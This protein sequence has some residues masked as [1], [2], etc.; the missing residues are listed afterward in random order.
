VTRDGT[1]QGDV[2]VRPAAPGEADAVANVLD[3]ALLEVPAEALD[4]A[5]ARG[6]CL[7]AVDRRPVGACLLEP[8]EEG[9]HVVA[10]AVRRRRRGQSIGRALIERAGGRGRLTAAF[11]PAVRPFYEACGFR[12]ESHPG[13][14]VAAGD[15]A[16]LWG[17]RD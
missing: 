5:L 7:V 9:T 10:I 1:A 16:S 15:E 13:P 2:T 3:G 4:A 6:D 11:R 8:R 17:V 12:I 14:A